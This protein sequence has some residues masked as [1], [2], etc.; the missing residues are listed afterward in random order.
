MRR[1]FYRTEQV[2]PV[3][4]RQLNI[5]VTGLGRGVGT[6]LVAASAAF[7]FAEN[8][9]S[10]TFTECA[11]P[12][13]AEGL[14]YDGAA[15]DQ[16]FIGR[17]FCPVYEVLRSG[18]SLRG[19]GNYEM[20]I[21]WRLITPQDRN[22]GREEAERI[23]CRLADNAGDDIC[24]FDVQPGLIVSDGG[25]AVFP[26]ADMD[27]LLVVADPMPS[28]LAAGKD[29]LEW[30]RQAGAAE[31]RPDVWFAVSGKGAGVSRRQVAGFLGGRNI[32]WIPELDRQELYRDEFHCRFHWQNENVR[33]AMTGVFTKLSQSITR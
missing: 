1:E 2:I 25:H 12:S 11:V 32:L 27:V 30:I 8:G 33:Q 14:L 19:R 22:I 10:V 13:E 17:R 26:L 16:R 3:R 5:A 23:V 31:G 29:R 28:R 4:R 18:G 9:E 24:I 21:N 15:M 7:Y 6:T 20:N